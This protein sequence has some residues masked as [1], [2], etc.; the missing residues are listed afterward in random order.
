M[1]KKV[2]YSA[3]LLALSSSLNAQVTLVSR[4]ELNNN[5]SDA[6]GNATCA[7][8]NNIATSYDAG[9]FS[10]TA[11]DT[12]GNGG[13]LKITI[14]DALFTENNYS[15]A[16][17]FRF[18]ETAGYRKLIDYSNLDSDRGLYVN[19]SLRLYNSGNYGP[20]EI[21][22]DSM[23]YVV[24]T[25]NSTNDSTHTYLWDG[26]TLR[27]ESIALDTQGD[28]VAAL[29]GTDRVLFFFADDSTTMSEYSYSG[30]VDEITIWN[31]VI[32]PVDLGV[33]GTPELSEALL[34][35]FP[36]PATDF[37]TV[38]TSKEYTGEAGL[39]TL[40]GKRVQVQ[41]VDAAHAVTFDLTTLPSGM[42]FVRCGNSIQP[43]VKR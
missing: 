2:L 41:Q 19:S 13:G 17:R 8:N 34:A 27:T 40:Q 39:F 38:R 21:P 18:S 9:I 16:V 7:S 32:S 29:S 4:F 23:I 25:R 28:Y 1:R 37:I 6:I 35:C 33:A 5:M 30:M 42:Y 10:W 12:I 43:I 36:N 14:P 20:T 15:V 11:N 3:V 26:N 31:G 22:V 24:I